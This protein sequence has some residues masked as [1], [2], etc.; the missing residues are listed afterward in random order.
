M[1]GSAGQLTFKR[2]N[3][4]TVVSEKVT[5]TTNRRTSAQQKQRMKWANIV[6]MYRGV[7]PLLNCA[8][9]NKASGVSD[10]NM[11]MK[12]NLQNTPVYLTKSEV[13]ACACVAAPYQI[14]QGSLPA[15]V[16]SGD[17]GQSVTDIAVGSLSIDADT[18]IAQFSNAVVEN[19][20]GYSYGDQISFIYAIQSLDAVS[21]APKCEF[22][23][24]AILL[25]K[26]S[27]VKVYDA[28]S[29]RGFSVSGG[30][31]AGNIDFVGAYAWIHSRK[32]SGS[33]LVSS[34][35][36]ENYNE[37]IYAE[38]TGDDA[39]QRA[40]ETYGGEN[41]TF[42]TPD[43]Q[44]ESGDTPTPVTT[45]VKLTLIAGEHGSVDPAGT[46]EYEKGTEVTIKAVSDSGY[47]FDQWSDGNYNAT[48]TITM[49]ADTELTASFE[50]I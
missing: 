20:S 15:I 44:T 10:Y 14:T 11:F 1:T 40:V 3:G 17:A 4:Q 13:A 33:T 19:N 50:A 46:T 49:D 39:Y 35:V 42:L 23:G 12:L 25:D 6:A 22:Y 37:V 36:M 47:Q 32:S 43:E 7:A 45:K 16:L 18:T 9:E 30:Y 21:G 31:L 26:S 2:V 5:E 34:Q 29:Q 8:F 48:R 27:E 41:S 24:E 28:V 38:Y